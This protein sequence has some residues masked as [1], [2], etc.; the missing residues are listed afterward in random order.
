MIVLLL[1]TLTREKESINLS[2]KPV[3][4]AKSNHLCETLLECLDKASEHSFNVVPIIIDGYAINM[5]TLKI[6]IKTENLTTKDGTM[7]V[8]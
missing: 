2:N 3:H 1:S 7:S 8:V 4:N 6:M 5:K